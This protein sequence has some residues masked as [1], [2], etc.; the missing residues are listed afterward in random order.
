MHIF[1]GRLLSSSYTI[2]L[3]CNIITSYVRRINFELKVDLQTTLLYL[4][5]LNYKSFKYC[6]KGFWG[7]YSMYSLILPLSNNF[8]IQ[9]K[10]TSFCIVWNLL[11]VLNKNIFITWIKYTVYLIAEERIWNYNI[12]FGY[13]YINN[14]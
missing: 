13:V 3:V 12:F 4:D 9:R 14:S 5:L 2:T 10:V 1:W 6:R 7:M 11:F 8:F